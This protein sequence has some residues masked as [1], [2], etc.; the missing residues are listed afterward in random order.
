[1][2]NEK[3]SSLDCNKINEDA[4]ESKSKKKPREISSTQVIN[5]NL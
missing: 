1:M 5:N 2:E 3:Y 4:A